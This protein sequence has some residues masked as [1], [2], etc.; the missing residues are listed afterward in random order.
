MV[1]P[2][3]LITAPLLLGVPLPSQTS[4]FYIILSA[5]VQTGYIIFLS[6]AY[7]HGMISSIYPL[8]IGSAPL[9]SLSYWHYHVAALFLCRNTSE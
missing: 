6:N 3:F 2:Q 1:I 9:I 4:F 5:F 7:K 8:A